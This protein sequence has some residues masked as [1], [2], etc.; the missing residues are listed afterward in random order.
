M[1]STRKFKSNPNYGCTSR[2][3]DSTKSSDRFGTQRPEPYQRPVGERSLY[4]VRWDE[5]FRRVGEP[6]N[7]DFQYTEAYLPPEFLREYS[8]TQGFEIEPLKSFGGT[9]A[10]LINHWDRY[11]LLLAYQREVVFMIRV[12]DLD[13]TDRI[14]SIASSSYLALRKLNDH[15]QGH[16]LLLDFDKVD[17]WG[18]ETTDQW[19]FHSIGDQGYIIGIKEGKFVDMLFLRDWLRFLVEKYTSGF[20]TCGGNIAK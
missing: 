5:D 8:L 17:I 19:A 18:N 14:L 13:D 3:A 11:Y 2:P 4:I 10:F 15:P 16:Q 6:R 9:Q 12:D 1:M 7:G 20:A